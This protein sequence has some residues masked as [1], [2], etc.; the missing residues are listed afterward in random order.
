MLLDKGRSR[1]ARDWF[2]AAARQDSIAAHNN[3][4]WL[5]A[6]LDD[7]ELRDGKRALAHASVAVEAEP[8]PAHLDTLAAAYAETGQ[9]DRAIVIQ[10][11][12]LA[13]LL[14]SD[15]GLRAGLERRLQGYLQAQLW[16]E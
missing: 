15:D 11:E 2:A 16:R 5:L 13:A 8:S 10:R 14:P 4:A 7:A 6:T 9:F 3:L 1:Q 12:A